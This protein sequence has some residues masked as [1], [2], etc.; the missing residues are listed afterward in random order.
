MAKDNMFHCDHAEEA[1]KNI[2]SDIICSDIAD[3]FKIFGD[4]TR[5]KL[6]YAISKKELCVHDLA[7]ILGMNQPAVSHQ[8]KTLRQF[9]LVKMR[10]DGPKNYYVI[11]DDH[12]AKILL[13]GQEHAV[14]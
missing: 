1:A 14:E 6:L 3:F 8:L 4:M 11:N 9:K 10:K 5:V 12:I 7:I 13:I 2:P